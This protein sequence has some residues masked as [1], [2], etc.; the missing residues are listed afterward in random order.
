[1]EL[2]KQ[3]F[4]IFRTAVKLSVSG[5]SCRSPVDEW[6]KTEDFPQYLHNA[7]SKHQYRLW[8][9]D[10]RAFPA[11]TI[12]HMPQNIPVRCILTDQHKS[13]SWNFTAGKRPLIANKQGDEL[14]QFIGEGLS[15]REAF[16]KQAKVSVSGSD[17]EILTNIEKAVSD[18]YAE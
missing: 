5:R 18:F 11:K 8:N 15:A 7:T 4:L 10:E 17:E 2:T 6:L 1:M 3:S 12:G 13:L 16:Y 9:I 14:R